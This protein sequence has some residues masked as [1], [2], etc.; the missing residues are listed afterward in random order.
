VIAEAAKNMSVLST[1]LVRESM[2]DPGPRGKQTRLMVAEQ[3]RS[4]KSAEYFSLDL[5]LGHQYRDS[6]II[7]A[8]PADRP[9]DDDQWATTVRPG[10][11][12]PHAWLRLG[13]SSLDLAGPGFSVVAPETADTGSLVQAAAARR[14]PL[15]VHRG[16]T[17]DQATQWGASVIVMRPDHV[18]AWCGETVPVDANTLLDQITGR[19]AVGVVHDPGIPQPDH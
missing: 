11:R 3:I 14:V 2:D 4:T 18:V 12:I 16:R 5:V 17:A 19:V 7:A 10:R 8:D 1:Q 9:P 15:T 13:V 6:S